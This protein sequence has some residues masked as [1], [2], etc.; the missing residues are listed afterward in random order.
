[1]SDSDGRYL[2]TF[3]RARYHDLVTVSVTEVSLSPALACGML[4]HQCSGKLMPVLTA[5]SDFFKDSP[6]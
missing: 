5:S 1:M 6:L 4:S 3:R 2:L